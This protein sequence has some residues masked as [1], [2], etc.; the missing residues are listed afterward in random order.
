MIDDSM[1]GTEKKNAALL[2]VYALQE[3]AQDLQLKISDLEK[4][5]AALQILRIKDGDAHN[6]EVAALQKQI[7]EL[8]ESKMQA[9]K[10]MLDFQKI[11]ELLNI[12][13]GTNVSEQIIPKLEELKAQQQPLRYTFCIKDLDTHERVYQGLRNFPTQE[14][15]IKSGEAM[16]REKFHT[17]KHFAS[18][19]YVEVYTL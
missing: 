11:G 2:M 19:Y 13:L 16:K 1:T 14:Q 17:P 6:Q 3:G 12:K 5:N 10:V 18:G 15:A 4:D 7:E 9:I 8:R